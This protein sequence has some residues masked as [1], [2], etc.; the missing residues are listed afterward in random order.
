[1]NKM[2]FS[3]KWAHGQTESGFTSLEEATTIVRGILSGA[4]I[5]HSGDIADGGERTMF[6][7]SEE[8]A[9]DDDGSRAAGSI[10][11]RHA[12]Q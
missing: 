9:Q 12:S 11:R 5:G 6:W 1:M 3:I 10:V 2:T 8:L 7:A 4:V